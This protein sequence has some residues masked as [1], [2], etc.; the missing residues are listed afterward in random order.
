[1]KSRDSSPSGA[2]RFS[3]SSGIRPSENHA[4]SSPSPG[5]ADVQNGYRHR[6][7]ALPCESDSCSDENRLRTAR[8]FSACARS[9]SE[10]ARASSWRAR[11]AASSAAACCV[12]ASAALRRDCTANT[13][14]AAARAA[15]PIVIATVASR[16]RR[17]PRSDRSANASSGAFIHGALGCSRGASCAL[18]AASLH[19]SASRPVPAGSACHSSA[20]PASF[21]RSASGNA[22]RSVSWI[23]RISRVQP[24]TSASC[25]G[26][27]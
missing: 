6:L 9:A 1:M 18:R 8:A 16:A 26:S 3:T 15:M 27:A 5:G 11:A 19:S 4:S 22:S 12:R 25:A 24:R 23:Q 2:H 13:R 7:P 10:A 14:L 21:C 17:R 20:T